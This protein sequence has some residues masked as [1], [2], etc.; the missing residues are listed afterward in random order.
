[1]RLP[2]ITVAA[3]KNYHKPVGATEYV[4]NNIPRLYEAVP[5]VEFRAAVQDT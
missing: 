3:R 5:E 1:M 2:R 4:V